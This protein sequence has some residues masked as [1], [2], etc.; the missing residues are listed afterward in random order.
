[1]PWGFAPFHYGRWALVHGRWVWVPGARVHRP[2][3]APALVVFVGSDI[4]IGWFP[5]GPRE[6]YLPAY[7]ASR[8]YIK[9]VNVT[10]VE[11]GDRQT[12]D[13]SR[14][15]YAHREAGRVYVQTQEQRPQREPQVPMRVPQPRE[16]RP[17]ASRSLLGA[18]A[19]LAR[20]W[21]SGHGP[22]PKAV[23]NREPFVQQGREPRVEGGRTP[24]IQ[25]KPQMVKVRKKKILAN[26]QVIWVEEWVA[27]QK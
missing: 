25:Q 24:K 27:V 3:Y 23:R 11:I 1:M 22:E 8:T 9:N 13:A 19:Q 6:P 7:P 21:S 5:L 4:K 20:E 18:I 14:I 16:S 12:I 15:R 2:V 10:H 17:A 26:G